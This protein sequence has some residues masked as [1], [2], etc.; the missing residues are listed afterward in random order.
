MKEMILISHLVST[1][2]P[3]L[4]YTRMT[5][6]VPVLDPVVSQNVEM[7]PFGKY[8]DDKPYFLEDP[9]E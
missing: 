3:I 6:M 4:I 7:Q 2:I 9:K 5:L 8:E 1:L